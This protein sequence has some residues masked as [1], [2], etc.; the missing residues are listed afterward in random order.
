MFPE[1]FQKVD[2][3]MCSAALLDWVQS[4][5]WLLAFKAFAGTCDAF[6]FALIAVAAIL[7]AGE[8]CAEVS[9]CLLYV[10]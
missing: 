9:V 7:S 1:R 3:L 8:L 10:W 4:L 5:N 6:M 2:M